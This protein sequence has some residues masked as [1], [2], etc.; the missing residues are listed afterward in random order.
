MDTEELKSNSELIEE[1]SSV[2]K[3][4]DKI[5]NNEET[6]WSLSSLPNEPTFKAVEKET[7]FQ[8][9]ETKLPRKSS[10]RT[11]EKKLSK[12]KA[13]KKKSKKQKYLDK[14]LRYYSNF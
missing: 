14:Q 13:T 11:K 9:N 6:M 5:I 1:E 7:Y 12:K 10:L 3:S 2:D 8:G 4:E